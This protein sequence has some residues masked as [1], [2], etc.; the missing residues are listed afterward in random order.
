LKQRTGVIWFRQDLRLRDNIALTDA[1]KSC[2]QIIPV[3]IFDERLYSGVSSYG[4]K[5]IGIQRA[6]F[7]IDSVADLRH[8]LRDLGTDLIVRFGK[9]EE[10]LFDIATQ[11]KTSWVFCNR[12]RTAEE[13]FNNNKWTNHEFESEERIE[14]NLQITISEEYTASSFQADFIFQ[15]I[16]PVYNSNYTTSVFTFVDKG[17]RVNYEEL[18]AIEISNGVYIDELSSL[19]TFYAYMMIGFD[20][21]SFSY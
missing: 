6:K 20:F 5:R 15:C 14:G 7:I 4:F 8:S 12:E 2:D 3:Y 10:V 19:L 17:L 21:D 18:Q 9:P 13:F 16:R 11:Y 1:I